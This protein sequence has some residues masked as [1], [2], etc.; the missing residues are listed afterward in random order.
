M[1]LKKN[2]FNNIS[3]S[4]PP[5]H[6]NYYSCPPPPPPTIINVGVYQLFFLGSSS[7]DVFLQFSITFS[8]IAVPKQEERERC[9]LCH[10]LYCFKVL[11][12]CRKTNFLRS[13]QVRS[14]LASNRTGCLGPKP[15]QST[16]CINFVAVGMN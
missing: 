1:N 15:A 4:F 10:S 16:S 3:I 14:Q 8:S 2:S 9:Y 7:E 13:L 11:P 5:L 12:E 6:V